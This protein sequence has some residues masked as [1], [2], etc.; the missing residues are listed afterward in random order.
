MVGM[1][2]WERYMIKE[3]LK[4]FFLIIILFYGFYCLIDYA[5]H[6]SSNNSNHIQP[7]WAQLGLYYTAEFSKRM[8]VLIPF[9]LLI[10]SLRVLCM[11]NIHRELVALLACGLSKQALLKPFIC[12][13]LFFVGLSYM[14]NEFFLPHAYNTLK[15][16]HV[17]YQI[18][19]NKHK[20]QPRAH[21]FLLKDGST[22][23]Y[24]HYDEVKHHLFDVYW[25]Q[26]ADRIWQMKELHLEL[27]APE[28]IDVNL[29][30][31]TDGRLVIVESFPS[32]S[33][34]EILFNKRKL[35][36]TLSPPDELSITQL[37]DKVD[38]SN[39]NQSEKSSEV[40]TTFYRKMLMP[41]LPL[42][43]LLGPAPF[44][45]RYSRTFPVFFIFAISIFALVAFYLIVDAT[46]VLGTR[47]LVAPLIAIG[48]PF[49]LT[50]SWVG[51]KVCR[52]Q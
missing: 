27:A 21:H 25:V 1:K 10:S 50:W 51:Y 40:L 29:L 31:R 7:S 36:E 39:P 18:Q 9:A 46:S 12:V 14:N 6:T 48:L 43:A 30:S 17:E 19:Q 20:K 3:L 24:H 44:C 45:M 15:S 8:D 52:A 49:L 16:I 37:W 4:T 2:I 47:Q 5:A 35:Y 32:R 34:T 41:W 23:L 28:G 13:G 22:I 33:F 11:L 42:L 26:S 38:T